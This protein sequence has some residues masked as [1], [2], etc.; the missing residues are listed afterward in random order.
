MLYQ[1]SK[2]QYDK[3]DLILVDYMMGHI[4]GIDVIQSIRIDP[5]FK[6]IPRRERTVVQRNT[7]RLQFCWVETSYC[8][9]FLLQHNQND[10]GAFE[11]C[12]TSRSWWWG[13]GMNFRNPE[14]S[15][16]T[17]NRPAHVISV[18]LR[19]RRPRALGWR[20]SLWIIRRRGRWT[21]R[22][23]CKESGRLRT[24]PCFAHAQWPDLPRP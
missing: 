12:F 19:L 5:Y 18:L 13:W 3:P 20:A 9:F 22:P 6:K 16:W 10:N 24:P 11:A 23:S 7:S 2:D 17:R 8:P 1:Q 15:G 4:T 21:I 14:Q